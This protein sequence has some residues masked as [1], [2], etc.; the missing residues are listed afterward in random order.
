MVL[1]ERVNTVGFDQFAPTI[2]AGSSRIKASMKVWHVDAWIAV[3]V[4]SNSKTLDVFLFPFKDLPKLCGKA[5]RKDVVAVSELYK[6]PTGSV[7]K[8]F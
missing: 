4:G 2:P 7:V 5:K 3:V 8:L 6:N 1:Q